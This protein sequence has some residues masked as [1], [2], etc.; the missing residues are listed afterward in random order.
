MLLTVQ[1]AV[2]GLGGVHVAAVLADEIGLFRLGGN[3]LFLLA[4]GVRPLV[5]KVVVGVDVLQQAALFDAAYAAG[6]PRAVQLTRHGVGALI[7]RVVVHGFVDAHAP[8]D[9]GRMVAVLPHHVLGIAHRLLLPVRIPDVLPAGDLGE[10]QQS[11]FVAAVDKMLRLGIVRGAHGVE[12]QLALENVGIQPLH[13]ARHRVADV[14]IALVA[15]EPDQLQFP[16][17]EVKPVCGEHRAAEAEGRLRAVEHGFAL[18]QLGHERVERGAERVPQLRA[19]QL[20]VERRGLLQIEGNVGHRGDLFGQD[21]FAEEHLL[22]QGKFLV[23][24]WLCAVEP[25]TAVD[26][27]CKGHG[28]GSLRAGPALQQALPLRDLRQNEHIV[29]PALLLDLQSNLT[30][31]PAV[32][33]IVDHIAERWDV[34]LLPAVHADGQQRLAAVGKRIGQLHAEGR[35]AA[36][37]LGELFPAAV[38]LRTV[39]R[40]ADGEKHALAAPCLRHV[41]RAPVAADHLIDAFVKVVIGRL[42]AGV[43]QFHR[44]NTEALAAQEGVVPVLGEFPRAVECDSFCHGFPHS[45]PLP[46][47]LRVGRRL[48]QHAFCKI[49]VKYYTGSQAE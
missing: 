11:Q 35:V 29:D 45:T 21:P 16:A 12:P 3:V 47:D 42:T 7:E 17:I 27:S 48:G 23:I 32:G 34:L 15:V 2:I 38:D 37:V 25:H 44:H 36:V 46:C 20:Q 9:D 39:S 22:A 18:P 33:H 14:R 5:D 49:P 40:R 4:A 10:Y 31:K 28:A 13:R 41:Q 43:R 19:G 1:L 24:A 30:V 8:E 26:G 6:L